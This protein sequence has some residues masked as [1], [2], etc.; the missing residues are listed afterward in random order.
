MIRSKVHL[1][2]A[3]AGLALTLG[4]A[5]LGGAAIAQARSA[6]A[7]RATGQVGEQAD[8]FLACVASC[9]S[10][11]REAVADINARR[12]AAYREVAQRTGVT[13]AAAAQAAAQRIIAN[14]PAGQQYRPAGGG[15][16]RK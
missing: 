15:W 5:A 8:G 7:L 4:S 11:T 2:F 12:A 1:T 10:A 13:E 14:L 6:D 3:A 9:D 16:T